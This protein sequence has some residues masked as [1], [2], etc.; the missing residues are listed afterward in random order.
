MIV[1]IRETPHLKN[2]FPER[3]KRFDMKEGCIKIEKSF[4]VRVDLC[5]AFNIVWASTYL[6][7]AI[8]FGYSLPIGW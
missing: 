3:A 1:Q 2:Y 6:A 4:Y 5:D 7:G 8:R